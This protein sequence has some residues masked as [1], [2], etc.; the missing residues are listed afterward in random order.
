M[1][2]LLW[3]ELNRLRS[4]RFTLIALLA[5]F[6]ALA[7]FQLVVN[8]EVTPP[9]AAEQARYQALYEE[10]HRDWVANHQAYEQ[11]CQQTNQPRRVRDPRAAAERLRRRQAV[12]GGGGHLADPRHVPG[13][14]GDLPRRRQLHRS[15][16]LDRFD[17]QLADLHPTARTGLHREARRRG[18]L[19]RADQRPGVGL[20]ARRGGCTGPPPRRPG[21]RP[22]PA[23][24]DRRPRHR[25]R[26]SAGRRRLLRG[27][28]L[29]AHRCRHRRAAGLP[30]HLVRARRA[31]GRAELR[32]AVDPV[33]P[34][35]KPPGHRRERAQVRGSDSS[36][37]DRGRRR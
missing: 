2:R 13:R 19:R 36:A 26:R 32:P 18:G 20:R 3:A 9:S 15:R 31:A 23:R 11:Q 27:A 30:V 8:D 28:D 16:V 34:G 25:G 6:L 22:H 29:P 21:V 37:H 17:R 10:A 24:P 7:A 14:A 4:R 1:I 35:S 33:D 5:V 12:P